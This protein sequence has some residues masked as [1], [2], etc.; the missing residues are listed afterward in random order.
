MTKNRRGREA[1]E[2]VTLKKCP[3]D[4][5]KC[6]CYIEPEDLIKQ[7]IYCPHDPISYYAEYELEGISEEERRRLLEIERESEIQQL[8]SEDEEEDI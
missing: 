1:P 6:V 7:G 2:M 5:I 8:M 4:G 3:Y